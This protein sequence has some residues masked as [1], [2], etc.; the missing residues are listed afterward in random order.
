MVA[1]VQFR[2]QAEPATFP[3]SDDGRS[4][5]GVHGGQNVPDF[6]AENLQFLK[7]FTG[8]A[9]K[10]ENT[11]SGSDD[12]IIYGDHGASDGQMEIYILFEY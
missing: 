2:P 4:C 11:V 10:N 6:T 1:G 8:P 9:G 5:T 12:A 7:S 3:A